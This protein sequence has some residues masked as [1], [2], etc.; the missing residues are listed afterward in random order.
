[1]SFSLEHLTE[2][3]FEQFCYDLLQDMGYT[4]LSWRKGTAMDASPADNG[5]DIECEY[6]FQ[7]PD[8]KAY[9]EK[10]FVECKHHKRG[11]PPNKLHSILTWAQAERPRHILIIAS[12]FLSNPAKLFLQTYEAENKP[13]FRIV[14]WEK[15]DLERLVAV[16]SRLRTR[17]RLE[18]D[19]PTL[20]NIHPVHVRYIRDYPINSLSFLFRVL[21]SL[22]P[23]ERDKFLD[24]VLMP[25]IQPRFRRPVT[26]NESIRDLM[27]D[28]MDYPNFKEKCYD[29]DMEEMLLVHSIVSFTLSSMYRISDAS[30][31]DVAIRFHKGVIRSAQ[32]ELDAGSDRAEV[33]RRVLERS[34]EMIKSLPGQ[35]AENYKRYQAFC[36]KVVAP[37]FA[38]RIPF[39]RSMDGLQLED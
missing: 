13:P 34:H 20:E 24:W 27:L 21:D 1:M 5:R 30:T 14:V 31:I 7:G 2:T 11:V 36:E 18:P 35:V 16:R 6:P 37:L 15:P 9:A 38:E 3:E 25:V 28:R 29:S 8:G 4:E 10:W 12:G 33:L 23:A 32:Q 17:Y 22:N 39:P 26:G 19:A